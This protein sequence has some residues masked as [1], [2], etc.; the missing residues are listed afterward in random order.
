MRGVPWHAL[1]HAA[2]LEG[3]AAA[4]AGRPAERVVDRVLRQH[5][6]LSSQARTAVVEAVY[7][8]ALW[9]RR[10]DP[11][12]A[13]GPRE[14]L[15]SLLGLADGGE[16]PEDFG[17]RHSLPPWLAELTLREFGRDA[18]AF[19]D[20]LNLPGPIC[21]RANGLKTS[22]DR[23]ATRLRDEGVTTRPGLMAPHCLVV[24]GP[25]PN[26]LPLAS[27]RDGWFEVQDE[28]SQL[29]GTLVEARPGDS[30]LDLCAGAGGKSL[31]LA[32]DMKNRGEL[33]V[34]DV[35][36]ERL[37]RLRQRAFRAGVLCLRIHHALPEELLVDRV[38]V[39]S[40][41]SELGALR[42]GPDARFRI[43]PGGFATLPAL[44]RQLLE[45]ALRHLRP[46]GR[47]VY[48]TCTFRREEN[49]EVA[50]DFERAHPE[51]RRAQDFFRCAPHSHGTDAF[52]AAVY[53]R[54]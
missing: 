54:A 7:G 40:P 49:E 4:L 10:L 14:L 11:A 20:A 22:R 42:R 13:K 26:L 48:A 27:F 3:I 47:L 36:H 52:F 8:V 19:A 30:V 35:D 6:G 32:A 50:Q 21:L 38:L 45:T 1:D 46:G 37:E 5:R 39:D 24:E 33:H 2:A 53:E 18:D 41:C 12:G 43:H 23:L 29:L 31:L 16:A 51:V 17:V 28:G 44:Q 9:R 34:F 25:R 15:S